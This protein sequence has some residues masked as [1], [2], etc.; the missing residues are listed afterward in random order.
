MQKL[1]RLYAKFPPRNIIARSELVP[2]TKFVP[3]SEIPKD[4]TFFDD[5]P[6]FDPMGDGPP[7]LNYGWGFTY[8]FIADYATR[9]DLKTWLSD[10][11]RTSQAN[12]SSK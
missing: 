4:R 1:K 9:H 2:G 11:L 6:E 12:T 5:G 10:E 3:R 7:L 8:D